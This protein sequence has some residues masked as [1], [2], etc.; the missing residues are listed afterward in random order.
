[1][2]L[3]A[4]DCNQ[5]PLQAKLALFVKHGSPSARTHSLPDISI[6]ESY[7]TREFGFD[8]LSMSPMG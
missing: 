1:L 6:L 4:A 8:I 2:D 7:P 5:E 3:L